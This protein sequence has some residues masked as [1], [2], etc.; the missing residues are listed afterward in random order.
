MSILFVG[1]SLLLFQFRVTSY[2]SSFKDCLTIGCSNEK[3]T[4]GMKTSQ[5]MLEGRGQSYCG[6]EEQREATRGRRNTSVSED[7]AACLQIQVCQRDIRG[8]SITSQATQY[9]FWEMIPIS[10]RQGK[11]RCVY[12]RWKV[13]GRI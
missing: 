12:R 7:L 3:R 1:N 6:G 5:G 4:A 13:F 10:V 2:F 9:K 8:H 11:E